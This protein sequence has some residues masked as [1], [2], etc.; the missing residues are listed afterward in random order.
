MK[1][2]TPKQMFDLVDY[3]YD[4]KQDYEDDYSINAINTTLEILSYDGDFIYE[5]VECA[6][7]FDGALEN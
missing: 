7:K 4:C 2:L 3:L 1:R 5:P 6:I